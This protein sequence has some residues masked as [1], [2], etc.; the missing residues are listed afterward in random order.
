MNYRAWIDHVRAFAEG[1]QKVPGKIACTIQIDPPLSSAALSD[2]ESKWSN[3]LPESL[4]DLWTWGSGRVSCQ[5]VWTPTREELPRLNEIFESND[6]IYGGDRFEPAHALFPGNSGADPNDME[7]LGP[8]GR[9]DFD[10]LCKSALFLH[11]GNGDYL[12]LDTEKN[13]SDPPVVYHM[14][15]EPAS[16]YLSPSF[17]SFLKDWTELSF[18]GPEF[19]LLDYWFVRENGRNDR[20]NGRID[21]TRHKTDDLRRLLSPRR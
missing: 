14:H 21:T 8:L 3:G 12:G 16:F 4:K 5:Y 18:I 17:S 6:Y 10:R 13:P 1:L 15:D 19:W 2:L 20:E 7:M 9:R 11:V